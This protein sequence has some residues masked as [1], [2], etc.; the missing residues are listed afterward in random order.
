MATPKKKVAEAPARVPVRIHGWG[1]PEQVAYDISGGLHDRLLQ[2]HFVFA[3]RP[4]S[5]EVKELVVSRRGP[6]TWMYG[7]VT[8][9]WT[10][11]IP[12]IGRDGI[13]GTLVPM[14]ESKK[15]GADIIQDLIH[16]INE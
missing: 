1:S 11:L 13:M 16:Y 5:G 3:A 4:V 10:G 2:G 15:V 6:D 7:I 14:L 12:G 9:G 8:T